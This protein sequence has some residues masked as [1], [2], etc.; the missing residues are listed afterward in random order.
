MNKQGLA[1]PLFLWILMILLAACDK[2]QNGNEQCELT[3]MDPQE[4]IVYLLFSAPGYDLPDS[5][6][7]YAASKVVFSGTVTKMDCPDEVTFTV[8]YNSA[9]LPEGPTGTLSYLANGVYCPQP[10]PFTFDNENDYL[11]VS[12]RLHAYFEDGK[13][14]ESDEMLNSYFYPDIK[15]DTSAARQ[16]ILVMFP[17]LLNFTEVPYGP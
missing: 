14:Y 4:P 8:T 16:Y 10:Y 15:P 17:L 1:S 12:C 6:Y 7:F 2:N 13:I 5:H 3:R 9:F 11:L